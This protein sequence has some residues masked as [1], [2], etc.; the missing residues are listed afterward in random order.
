MNDHS[1]TLGGRRF[2]WYDMKKK[3]LRTIN[4]ARDTFY[5]TPVT[6]GSKDSSS[7]KKYIGEYYSDEAN[8]A[9][10]VKMKDGKL[11]LFM[12]PDKWFELTPTY[13]DAFE[14]GLGNLFFTVDRNGKITGF[15]ASVDRAR[16]IEFR[17]I[18]K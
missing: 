5:Y 8:A 4:G 11:N 10:S 7:W 14:F 6:A 18:Q 15:K 2:E 17:K 13:K 16:N 12:Q 3:L 9:Y 1:F